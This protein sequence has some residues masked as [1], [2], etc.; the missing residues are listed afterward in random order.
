MKRAVIITC[1]AVIAGAIAFWFW[2]RPAYRRH[3]EARLIEQAKSFMARGDYRNAS[4]SARQTLQVNPDNLQACFIVAE[5]A[6]RSHSPH[7]LDWRRRIVELAPTTENKLLLAS[8]ALRLQ[9]APFPLA[10]Q[11]LEDLGDSATNVAGYHVVSAELALRL[12]KIAEAEAHFLQACQIE[13]TNEM[14]RLDLAVL[15]L[16]STNSET[17]AEARATLE[18]L[19]ASTNFGAVALRWLVLESARKNDLETAENLCKQLL[20]NN[21]ASLDDRLEYLNLLQQR[22][23]PEFNS[24][25]AELRKNSQTNAVEVYAISTWMLGHNLA[26]EAMHWLTNCP[27]K[28]QSE[29]PVP[30]ALVDCYIAAKDWSGLEEFLQARK[31]GD[32][33]FLRQ[34]FLSK[35]ALEQDQKIAQEARWRAAVKE[36]GDRLGALTTLLGLA[37]NWGQDRGREDL[38]WQIATR[39]PRERWALHELDR[40]YLAGGDTVGLNRVYTTM[41]SYDSKS[42]FA[43]NNMAAT[44]LLLKRNL[45]KAYEMAK[46]VYAQHPDE[47]IVVSTYAYAMYLQ[48]RPKDGLAA[49]EKLKPDALENPSIA[50]YYGVLL[51]AGGQTNKAPKFLAL[52]QR[53]SLLPEEKVLLTE[54]T[55][56]LSE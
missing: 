46:E 26:A 53:A 15:R 10:A 24:E 8:T 17:A 50:L 1:S 34:A 35:A 27:A 48:G 33:E 6:E 44:S 12:H 3:K 20:T 16:Q 40:L 18:R 41:T 49:F 22:K 38:L 52:A 47:P 14:H 29:Q 11:T 43:R 9:N 31:W 45:P 25:V 37:A 2:G 55:K 30:V 42:V 54:T 39:F 28:I 13:P 36:A 21:Q 51:A 7:A 4:L 5:L 56:S 23:E 19:R 32:L